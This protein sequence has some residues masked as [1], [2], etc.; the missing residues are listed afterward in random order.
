MDCQKIWTMFCSDV[1]RVDIGIIKDSIKYMGN[2][3]D[4]KRNN[5][6]PQISVQDI[7]FCFLFF[8]LSLSFSTSSLMVGLCYR[9]E[10]QLSS[11]H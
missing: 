10:E 9:I 8:L 5:I 3:H 7:D 11:L 2:L 1:E 6:I 4:N